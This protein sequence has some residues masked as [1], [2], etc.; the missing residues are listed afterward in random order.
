[1]GWYSDGRSWHYYLSGLNMTLFIL[2]VSV[3][4]IEVIA[5]HAREYTTRPICA[6][7]V[8]VS[9]TWLWALLGIKFGLLDESWI[10]FTALLMGASVMGI[11]NKLE[12]I[13]ARTLTW[14]TCMV[15]GGLIIAGALL[16]GPAWLAIFGAMA[17]IG[18]GLY[19]WRPTP[20]ADEGGESDERKKKLE[21]KM[22]K[23]C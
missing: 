4:V 13:K 9:T 12:K 11:V 6:L 18:F 8:G 1:M 15:I 10:T 5:F 3:V 20:L 2:L 23:C 16:Y 19:I 17:L 7:C 21:E 14:R 22:K